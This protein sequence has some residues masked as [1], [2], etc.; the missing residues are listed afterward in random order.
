MKPPRITHSF[1]IRVEVAER[2]KRIVVQDLKSKE[3][4]EFDSWEA[5]SR[6]LHIRTSLDLST[7]R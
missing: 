3:R 4:L 6:H 5:L 1:I 2:G 7:I